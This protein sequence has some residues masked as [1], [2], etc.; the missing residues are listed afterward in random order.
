[1][2]QVALI[3]VVL[4]QMLAVALGAASR[5]DFFDAVRAGDAGKTK[6]LLLAD[7]KLAGARTED[8]STALHLAAL[9]GQTE[10]VRLLLNSRADVNAR[11]LREET[12]LH[13]AMYDGH[14][15]VVEL[16]LAKQANVNAQNSAGETP[17]HVAERKGYRDLV[18]MLLNHHA[19]VNVKD[20]QE[21]TP[22]HAA[23]AGGHKEVVELLLSQNADPLAQ[24]KSGRTPK[25]VALEKEHG[26]VAELLT[27]RVGDF[28]DLQRVVFEGTKTFTPQV[29]RE[30]L[31]D[32]RDFFVISHPLAPQDAFLEMIQQKLLIGYQHCGFPEA[33]IEARRDARAGRIVVKVEEGPRYRCGAVKVSGAQKVPAAA[34]IERVMSS[35]ARTRP[36][37]P[38]FDFQDKAPATSPLT[39]A[40]ATE[41]KPSDVLWVKGEPAP[42]AN[43]DL[44]HMKAQVTDL[45]HERGFLLAKA[46]VRMVPNPAART[47]ELQVEVLEEGP[48]AVIDRIDISGNRTN[49]AE[50]VLRYLDLKPGMELS[51]QLMASIEDRLWRAARFLSYQVTVGSSETEGR[52]PLQ[53]ELVEYDE[54]PPLTQAFTPTEQALLKLREWLSK[55]DESGED[56]VI[57]LSGLT[58]P[59]PEGEMV[60][61]P[62]SGLAVLAKDA[63]RKDVVREEYAI[64]VKAGQVGFY[65][66]SG[67]RKLLLACP[68]TQLRG[69]FTVVINP[70][71]TNDSPFNLM[72]GASFAHRQE[73]ATASAAY[74]FELGLPPAVCIGFAHQWDC[75]SWF[76]GDVLTRSN[77]TMLLKLNARTGRLLEFRKLSDEGRGT[78]EIHTESGAFGRTVQRIETGANGLADL[79]NTNAPLSSAISFFAEEVWTSKYLGVIYGTNFASETAARLPTLLH[80]FKLGEIL[81][82]L[83]RL[84]VGTNAPAAKQGAF[85]IPEAWSSSELTHFDMWAVL[86]SWFLHHSDELF[87]A[88]S[89]PWTLLRETSFTIQHK[90]TYTDQALKEVYESSETG[91]LGYLAFAQVLGM[92]Q[93]PTARKFA[94]RGLERLSTADFR[95]DWSLLLAGNSVFSQC[96]LRLAATLR[97]MS[98]EQIAA[99]AKEQSIL[100]G[101]FIAEC[102]RRLR[103]AKDQPITNALA[104]VFDTYWERELKE[105]V[106]SAVQ[107]LTVD[108]AQAFQEAVATL[109]DAAADKTKAVKVIGKVAAHGHAG[110]QYCMAMIYERGNGVP[111]DFK[112]ALNWYR[113]SATNGLPEAALAL[114]NY[115]TEGLEVEKDAAEAFVWY[116]V[117]VAEGNRLA[118]AL[119]KGARSKLTDEQFAEA[120]KRIAAIVSHLPR[121][122]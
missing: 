41:P 28:Y 88:H 80:Q 6:A 111:K 16:L 75:V 40:L 21:G 52:V 78:V 119:R 120:A 109:Q 10:I 112:T 1:M 49:T 43:V 19:E 74:Q 22:L 102:S 90:G 87:A 107:E 53:I 37:Q 118:E 7:S 116:S 121:A 50:A 85:L 27:L 122:Q 68:E 46:D 34:M 23:A 82:P 29:L 99:L 59:A 5:T 66:P 110:A 65:S 32:T 42:F 30:E 92:M 106:K 64:L 83:D 103:A 54:A 31:R 113:Q 108:L 39:Q 63:T 117:A 48:R 25:A 57:N 94:A 47:A 58:A 115:Y 14:R 60:M 105:Q 8:G 45:L 95:R 17:L 71:P 4:T 72:L 13:M 15:E 12:P 56:L 73:G 44:R 36:V 101:E 33:R 84:V 62:R 89:W 26:E 20:Q 91:P 11:G 24:D 76:E 61:S 81:S 55:L 77:A 2:K 79:G 86:T 9:E 98:D 104:P 35:R 97:D 18:E 69:Y 51:G 114:G 96:V 70:A 38:A 93:P 3:C 100:R 67:G